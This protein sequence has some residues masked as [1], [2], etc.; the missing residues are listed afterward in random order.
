L[1]PQ[2]FACFSPDVGTYNE[3]QYTEFISKNIWYKFKDH[4]SGRVSQAYAQIGQES[5]IVKLFD[6]YLAKLPRVTKLL[7]AAR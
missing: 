5:C 2:L 3:Y 7:H 1:T 6:K 4:K